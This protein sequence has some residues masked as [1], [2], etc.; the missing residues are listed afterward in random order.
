MF[1]DSTTD[2]LTGRIRI[3]LIPAQRAPIVVPLFQEVNEKDVS[4]LYSP[5]G[6]L[7]LSRS[8]I[9]TVALA[10]RGHSHD[11]RCHPCADAAALVL[12]EERDAQPHNRGLSAEIS[13]FLQC[14]P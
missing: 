11:N 8:I 12:D 2:V 7:F 10:M 13:P 9:Q 5:R 6:E 3:F 4:K 1:T 14:N